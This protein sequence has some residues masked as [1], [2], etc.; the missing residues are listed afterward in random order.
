MG[1]PR[2]AAISLLE[3]LTMDGAQSGLT[4]KLVDLYRETAPG[5]CALI[6]A[7][8][9]ASCPLVHDELCTASRNAAGLFRTMRDAASA[10]ATAQN[11]VGAYGCPAAMFQ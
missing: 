9:N 2:E 4:P 8:F 6:G 10:S 7:Q 5:S 1:Q 3:G 11:A